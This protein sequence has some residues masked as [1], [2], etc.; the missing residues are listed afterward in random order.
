MHMIKSKGQVSSH[1]ADGSPAHAG[2]LQTAEVGK[3][4]DSPSNA[5]GN[6]P[7][8]DRLLSNLGPGNNVE[9][10]MESNPEMRAMLENPEQMQ[11]MMSIASNPVRVW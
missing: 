6:I 4:A 8:I 3:A 1:T 5:A 7:S 10:V 2:T 9:R 11:Q